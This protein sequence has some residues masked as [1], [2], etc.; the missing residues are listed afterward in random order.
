MEDKQFLDEAGLSEAGKVIKEHYASKEDLSKI[1]VT[2][3]LIDYAKKSD[4][5]NKIDKVNGKGLSTH[6]YSNEDKAKLD[7]IDLDGILSVMNDVDGIKNE[8]KKIPNIAVKQ[9]TTETYYNEL[10]KLGFDPLFYFENP[11]TFLFIT[12][13]YELNEY[14]SLCGSNIDVTGVF[15]FALPALII[16]LP[17]VSINGH[18]EKNVLVQYAQS[19]Y[20]NNLYCRVG[21]C[22]T[23]DGSH[24]WTTMSDWHPIVSSF[25]TDELDKM[26][27]YIEFLSKQFMEYSITEPKSYPKVNGEYNIVSTVLKKINITNLKSWFDWA[28]DSGAQSVMVRG[29]LSESNIQKT[30][31]GICWA[32]YIPASG[33]NNNKQSVKQIIFISELGIEISRKSKQPLDVSHITSGMRMGSDFVDDQ[34]AMKWMDSSLWTPWTAKI[35][36]TR[37]IVNN[38]TDGGDNIPLSA[39]QGK[40]LNDKVLALQQ[41]IQQLKNQIKE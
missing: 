35:V 26:K 3:Q 30:P 40:A 13:D 24:N 22:V 10:N 39:E 41:E 21:Q 36:N 17:M 6:D 31:S 20:N 11:I 8:L 7:S 1:D 9:Y 29:Q 23:H 28:C 25:V 12:S 38:L 4:L 5:D 15:S 37:P 2:E 32:E 27:G 34:F 33:E 18:K 16:T 19:L 14:D